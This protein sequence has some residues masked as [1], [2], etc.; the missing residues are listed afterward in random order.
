LLP[1]DAPPAKDPAREPERF[2][3]AVATV[4]AE[5]PCAAQTLLCRWFTDDRPLR[6]AAAPDGDGMRPTVAVAAQ[7]LL[8]THRRRAVDDLTEALVAAAHPLAD[9]LLDAL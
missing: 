4:L 6:A 9:E 7:A 8:H 2:L 1:A 5:D 3:P